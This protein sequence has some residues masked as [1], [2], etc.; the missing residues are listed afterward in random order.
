MSDWVIES[1]EQLH[2]FVQSFGKKVV[3]YRG[4][5]R[6]SHKL[7]PKVG[8]YLKFQPMSE[9]DFQKEERTI[10]R[11]FKEQARPFLDFRPET[12]WE[13]LAI[14]QH[15]GLPTRLL[16]WTRNP[17]V[18]AYFAVEKEYDGDSRIFAYRSNSYIRTQDFVD[19]LQYEGQAKFVPSHITP[20]ISAQV[21][22]FTIHQ[23][24]RRPFAS[25]WISTA[26]ILKSFRKELKRTL[27]GY[28]IH[29]ASLF[30]D[31]DNLAK[32]IEWLRTD[33]Y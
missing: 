30:P 17:L 9:E 26:V 19:P 4:V 32:H 18:A 8:R 28:G 33:I 5:T 15:H 16:D 24:P 2:Q 3:I 27:Y 25:R 11:L 20:R 12:E 10:L 21:G 31:L 29:R 6:I 22:V 1:F 14:A 13:W 23:Y 7:M